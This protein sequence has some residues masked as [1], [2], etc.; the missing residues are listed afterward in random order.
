MSVTINLPY[1]QAEGVGQG[2][3]ISSGSPGTTG[4]VSI[5]TNL[6]AVRLVI[7]RFDAPAFETIVETATTFAVSLS[8]IQTIAIVAL[9]NATGNIFLITNV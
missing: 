3:F 1:A 2:Y 9:V 5:T 6:G 8:N 4:I 7:T